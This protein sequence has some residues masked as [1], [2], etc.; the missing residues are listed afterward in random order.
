[1]QPDLICA[2]TSEISLDMAVDP[3][4]GD[5]DSLRIW[6]LIGWREYVLG[7]QFSEQACLVDEPPHIT[8]GTVATEV[9]LPTASSF[10]I[11]RLAWQPQRVCN[12]NDILAN[13]AGSERYIQEVCLLMV[14]PT[15][16]G[17][18]LI[19][20][21]GLLPATVT[22]DE[23]PAETAWQLARSVGRREDF[24]SFH[25]FAVSWHRT[26]KE[27]YRILFYTTAPDEEAAFDPALPSSLDAIDRH[28][29]IRHTRM[30]RQ[31]PFLKQAIS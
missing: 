30:I 11:P 28:S 6:T 26:D 3:K 20:P 23:H 24:S 18:P 27:W 31:S 2:T 9:S 15:T 29:P 16:P 17:K 4:P 14:C 21:G 1:M 12:E 13:L 19:A 7:G 5:S 22:G 10:L 25:R 8:S